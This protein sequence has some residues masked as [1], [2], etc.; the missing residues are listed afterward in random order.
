MK[1]KVLSKSKNLDNG[2]IYP[3]RDKN[4]AGTPADMRTDPDAPP[5]PAPIPPPAPPE[6]VQGAARASGATPTATTTKTS[7]ENAKMVRAVGQPVLLDV[8]QL[9]E[10]LGCSTSHVWRMDKAGALPAP[11]KLMRSVRWRRDE[12]EAW[13]DAGAPPRTRWTWP[14]AKGRSISRLAAPKASTPASERFRLT[15]M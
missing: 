4:L 15:N 8:K 14:P 12:V 10:M 1:E 5:T 9:A 6:G 3:A 11:L 13:V 2:A 7:T